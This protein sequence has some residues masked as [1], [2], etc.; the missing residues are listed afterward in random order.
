LGRILKH[1]NSSSEYYG[2]VIDYYKY[3]DKKEIRWIARFSDNGKEIRLGRYK[4]EIE[5][6]KS[7]DKKCWEMY[8]DLSKLNFPEDYK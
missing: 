8:H 7:F 2:V 1:K 3:K 4:T 6:A 5:A